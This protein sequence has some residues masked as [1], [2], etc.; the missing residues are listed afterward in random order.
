MCKRTN[1]A[2]TVRSFLVKSQEQQTFAWL[3]M[4]FARLWTYV[5][6]QMIA[7][8]RD[9]KSQTETNAGRHKTVEL[10]LYVALI[11]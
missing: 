2:L 4:S 5:Q 6:T 1:D 10:R 8:V 3:T 7:S 11:I 9:R